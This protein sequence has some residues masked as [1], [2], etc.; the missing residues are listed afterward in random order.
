MRDVKLLIAVLLGATCL[1]T[2]VLAQTKAVHFIQCGDKPA[3]GLPEHITEFERANPGTKIDLEVVGWSQCEQKVTT[4]AAAGDPPGLAYVGSRT[5]PQFYQNG[6]IMP[7]AMSD[8]E[9][10]AYYPSVLHSVTYDGK[11]LGVPI[12]MSTEALYWNKDL[13]RKAGLDPDKAPTTWQELYDDAKA[14]KDKTGVAGFG[15]PAK[16]YS[17]TLAIFMTWV[18]S[19]G[20]SLLENG[21]VTMNSPNVV[22]AVEWYKKMAEVSE[23]GPSAYIREDLRPM[24]DDSKIAMFVSVPSERKK[25]NPKVPFGIALP[26]AGPMGKAGDIVITDS[27]ATFKGTGVED[28]AQKFAKFLTNPE[29]QSAYEQA[30]GL[31]PMRQ[32]PQ[33]AA[34]V[35]SDPSW[36]PFVDG[37]AVAGPEPQFADYVDLQK[38]VGDMLQSVLLGQS[39]PAAA[40]A[41]AADHLTKQLQQ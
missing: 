39:T 25:I 7:V 29:N 5:L 18:Y 16:T 19:N 6:L 8:A 21:H 36:K 11:I 34:L 10:A 38:A 31:T 12:A 28:V 9:K 24:F 32:G 20:G 41:T 22:Q 26:P 17:S 13:F 1:A 2:P 37:V 35:A 30:Y 27:L 14:I 3:T 15:L 40:V 23:A 33:V 4:L